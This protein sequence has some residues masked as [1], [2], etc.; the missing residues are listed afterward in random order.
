MIQCV[1]FDLD[2]TL[3]D[4]EPLCNQAFIDLLPELSLPIEDLLLRFRGRKL[5][6]IFRDIE[7]MIG[8]DLPRD[9]E[10][11]YRAQ[12]DALFK[13]FLEA[14]PDVHNVLQALEI[15]ICIASSTMIHLYYRVQAF[16]FVA[17]GIC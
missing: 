16:E 13:S 6:D 12:V 8:R 14:F 3:V 4:S 2:G 1:I 5:A 15:N 17:C 11:A 10:A 9:F 7:I